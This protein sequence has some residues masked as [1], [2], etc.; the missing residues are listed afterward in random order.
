MPGRRRDDTEARLALVHMGWPDAILHLAD[1]L[2][3]PSER[4]RE[5]AVRGLA[6]L[7]GPGAKALLRYKLHQ[8]DAELDVDAAC[9]AGLMALDPLEGVKLLAPL[10]HMSAPEG[11]RGRVAPRREL[12]AFALGESRCD[13]A[14]PVLVDLLD[15]SVDPD[16][17]SLAATALGIHRTDLSRE[18]LFER[19]ANGGPALARAALRALEVQRFDPRTETRARE[20]AARNEAVEL[21]PLLE[22]IFHPED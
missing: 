17:R 16:H 12:A 3:D 10:L 8:G 15:R 11:R 18:A 22:Q 9:M 6:H 2:A 14:V 19:I 7:G 4:A 21:G 5:G 1:L 13:D 20:A